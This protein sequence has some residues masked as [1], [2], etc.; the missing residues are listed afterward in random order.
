VLNDAVSLQASIKLD[1]PGPV[2]VKPLGVG[3]ITVSAS[4]PA[5]RQ[6]LHYMRSR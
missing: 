1:K 6:C 2:E 4:M 5:A 3:R